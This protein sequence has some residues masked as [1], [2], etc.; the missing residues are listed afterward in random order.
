MMENFLQMRTASISRAQAAVL[1]GKSLVDVLQN[2]S[3]FNLA[4][5]MANGCVRSFA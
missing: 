5:W 3:S 1:S 4:P 2:A